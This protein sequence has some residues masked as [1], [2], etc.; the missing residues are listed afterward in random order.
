MDKKAFEIN[1][2]GLEKPDTVALKWS[3]VLESAFDYYYTEYIPAW[4][5]SSTKLNNIGDKIYISKKNHQWLSWENIKESDRP[6]VATL[7]DLL[8]DLP[9]DEDYWKLIKGYKGDGIDNPEDHFWEN[10]FS[11]KS[12]RE[13]EIGDH[14]Y[15][16]E[17][18]A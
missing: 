4:T 17:W 3:E 1:D 7:F 13:I 11:Y 15:K 6:D 9:V 16:I 8:P 12:S 2:I 10:K 5:L 14:T 18:E